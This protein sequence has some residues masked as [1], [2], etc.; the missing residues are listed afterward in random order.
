LFRLNNA[1]SK[2]RDA[3]RRDT[4]GR[5][6][7]TCPHFEPVRILT[8]NSESSEVAVLA[9]TELE[10]VT[11]SFDPKNAASILRHVTPCPLDS[12]TTYER[13]QSAH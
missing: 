13:P 9:G 7:H 10:F 11:A 1:E 8:H 12:T 4:D 3:S 5:A 6:I 2:R